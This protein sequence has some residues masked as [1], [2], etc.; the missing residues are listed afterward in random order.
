MADKNKAIITYL[1]NCDQIYGSVLY[2][3]FI[4]VKDNNTQIVTN[5]DDR[6]ISRP[7]IDGSV[8]RRYTFTI[9]K[10]K[11]VTDIPIVTNFPTGT[12]IPEYSNE[13]VEDMTD[14]Q[15]LI[16]WIAEQREN[17]VY[18]YF[19][20]DCQIDDIYTTT[21]TPR[22]DGINTDMSPTLAMYSVE[23]VV[24]YIDTSRANW[25]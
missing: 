11:S 17:H 10:F 1:L 9:I 5:S 21:D 20:E 24:D 23:I 25:K 3:N 14:M 8:K 22:L 7:Y 13:N 4:D 2:F 18:P 16:D 19:G 12:S 6:S 15:S